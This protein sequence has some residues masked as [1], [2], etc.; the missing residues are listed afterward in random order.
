MLYSPMLGMI[1]YVALIAIAIMNNRKRMR[2]FQQRQQQAYSQQFY[3][4]QS[5]QNSYQD[6]NQGY[7]SEQN[8]TSEKKIKD[9]ID[10]EFSE[11]E[12]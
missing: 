1:L 5:Q 10:V 3:Q 2:M 8:T 9:A 7:R 11:E 4:Q 6:T 12:I